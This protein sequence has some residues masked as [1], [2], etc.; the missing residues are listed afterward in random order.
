ML[1]EIDEIFDLELKRT[2]ERCVEV[3][4]RFEFHPARRLFRKRRSPAFDLP[5]IHQQYELRAIVVPDHS[6]RQRWRQQR[7]H[8]ARAG[9]HLAATGLDFCPPAD[10]HLQ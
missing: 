3:D 4:M 7:R 1:S 8:G 2:S 10:R 5:P 6:G 9:L